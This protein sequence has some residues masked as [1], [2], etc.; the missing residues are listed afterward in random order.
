MYI[1]LIAYS[2]QGMVCCSLDTEMKNCT[3]SWC[4]VFYYR[5]VLSMFSANLYRHMR[6]Y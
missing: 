6:G 2:I 3:S 1:V 4:D 5:S